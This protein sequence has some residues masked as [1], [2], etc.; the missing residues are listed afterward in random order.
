[1]SPVVAAALVVFVACTLLWLLSLRL[2][3]SSIVDPFW[4]TGFLLCALTYAALT[5]GHGGPRGVLVLGLCALWSLRLSIFLLRRNHGKGED[6][7]YRRMREEAGPSWWWRSYLQVFVLQGALM[8]VISQPLRAAMGSPERPLGALDLAGGL[9]FA[10]GFFFEAVGDA[11]LA[12]FRADPSRRGQV[13]DTG[14]WRY[15]R[16]PN[17]FGDAAQWWG[18]YLF[19]IAGGGRETVYSPILMTALLLKVSGVAL[20]E[21][22]LTKTKPG[23]EEYVRRTSAF[24]PRWPRPPRR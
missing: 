13:L 10:V 17:Y 2:R 8:L 20:L 24:I 4:G 5:P 22:T 3:D 19:A 14:L 1:M 21:R 11:Q 6:F 12:A 18:F 15:S 9:V 16:H 23:Y 7:R